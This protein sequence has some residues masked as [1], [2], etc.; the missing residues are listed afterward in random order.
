MAVLLLVALSVPAS[1]A[2]VQK[3]PKFKLKLVDG[4]VMSS[5]D[6][7]GKVTVIDFWGT[8]CAPCLL[9]IPSYNAFY[10]ERKDKGVVFLALAADSGTPDQVLEA[11]RH[12]KIE[13]PVA[14]PSWDEL[15]QFGNIE[16]FPTTLVFDGKGNLVKEY[17]GAFAGKQSGLREVVDRLLSAK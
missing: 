14:A 1:S 9:E 11:A 5:E 13:Y 16:A 7:A 10:R 12:L 4:S 3:L 2:P 8:W 15:D 6:L 17:L